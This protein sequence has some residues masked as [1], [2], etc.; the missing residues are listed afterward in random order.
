MIVPPWWKIRRELR[1][2]VDQAL[3]VPTFLGEVAWFELRHWL[4]LGG[5]R[6]HAGEC[7][8]GAD[9]AIYVLYQPKGLL[10][11][12]IGTCRHL[13]EKGYSVR[14][15]SNAPLSETDVARLSPYCHRVTE[16]PNHGYDFGAYQYAVNT[17]LS[18]GADL[19]NLLLLNDSVWFPILSDCDLLDRLR[20]SAADFAGPVLYRHRKE[21]L[22]H[23]QSYMLHFRRSAIENPAFARFWRTYRMSG[24]KRWT[25]R[26]GEMRLTSFLAE[27][28]LRYEGLHDALSLPGAIDVLS[29]DDL[30]EVLRYEALRDHRFAAEAETL[31]QGMQTPDGR[32]R[33]LGFLQTPGRKRYF[34]SNHPVIHLELLRCSILKKDRSPEFQAQRRAILERGQ[35]GWRGLDTTVFDEIR[36]GA[37]PVRIHVNPVGHCRPGPAA[38]ETGA[39]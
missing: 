19:E 9:V 22:T 3:A 23:L 1:R 6:C 20:A 13:A 35:A 30:S 10:A 16:R 18:E 14:V 5:V 36:A 31:A 27:G 25:I 38:A 33:S 4:S 37:H 12:T 39:E 8:P 26:F 11:S 7:G 28:G 15:V 29:D 17:L 21:R 34:L 24:S 2:I 32:A